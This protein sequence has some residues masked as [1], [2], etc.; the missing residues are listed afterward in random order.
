LPIEA[1]PYTLIG[2]GGHKLVKILSNYLSEFEK[3]RAGDCVTLDRNKII[4]TAYN[5]SRNYE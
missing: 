5:S 3:I 1:T 2:Y 4:L